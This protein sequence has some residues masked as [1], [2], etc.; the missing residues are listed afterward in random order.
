MTKSD[1][2]Y[3][4]LRFLNEFAEI[5][6]T[7]GRL[8][9]WQQDR[10]TYFVT[11]R[12][13]DS[14]PASEI[15]QWEKELSS[16]TD[17]NERYRQLHRQIA[18]FEDS[19]HGAAIFRDGNCAAIVQDEL[20]RHD[21]IKYQLHEWCIMPNHVHVLM[22]LLG[23]NTLADVIKQ[24]KGAASM[25]LNRLLGES[26]RLWQPDYFDR[27]VRDMEHFYDCRIYIRNNPV[28]AGLCEKPEDWPY[29][30]AA[31]KA[32]ERGL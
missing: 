3:P 10:A 25:K 14:V 8:P 26:G 7:H 6:K 4:L 15:K 24:W 9:H 20:L 2:A 23:E 31:W 19:G 28:K 21:G 27:Y 13:A 12:L 29:S 22:M 30:S 16:I 18:K 17:D 5:H 1:S 11:F 32:K